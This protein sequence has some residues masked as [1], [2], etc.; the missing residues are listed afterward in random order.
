VKTFYCYHCGHQ[1][2]FENTQCESCGALLGFLPDEHDMGTFSPVKDNQV[3][4][5]QN[6]RHAGMLYQPCFNYINENV[7]NWM[8]PVTQQHIYCASCQLTH[9]IPDLSIG[10]NRLYWSRLE[11]AKRRFLY[12]LK[13]LNIFPRPKLNV[14]DPEGLAFEFLNSYEGEHIL[15]G[16]DHGLITINVAEA[17]PSYR[18][19]TRESMYEP[20]RT[21]LGHFRHESGHYYFDRFIE[22]TAWLDEFRQIFGDETADYSDA[23]HNHYLHG[24][25]TGWQQHYVSSYASVHPWEDWAETWAHYLHM[26]ETLDTAYHSGVTIQPY[27]RFEPAMQFDQPPVGSL[28]FD[29]TLSQWFALAYALNALNRS[30]GLGDAYPFAL[31]HQVLNKLRFIHRVVLDKMYPT[32][33]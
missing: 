12:L 4:V 32:Q 13:Q 3:W 28:D 30:M 23:L 2:F 31:S 14:F 7:C 9:I 1:V 16:H 17:D 22:S 20:Y 25:P 27:N 6:P 18:E 11:A 26:M 10:S 8:I 15:T 24:A 19:W 5:S 33:I 29:Q 21:L